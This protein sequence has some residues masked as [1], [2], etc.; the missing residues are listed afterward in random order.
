MTSPFPS[1]YNVPV[2]LVFS[3]LVNILTAKGHAHL[4]CLLPYPDVE[5]FPRDSNDS[6]AHRRS[7]DNSTKS[8]V[9]STVHFRKCVTLRRFPLAVPRHVRQPLYAHWFVCFSVPLRPRGPGARV[10][11]YSVL[12]FLTFC[13]SIFPYAEANTTATESPEPVSPLGRRRYVMQLCDTADNQVGLAANS[14]SSGI[15]GPSP[16]TLRRDKPRT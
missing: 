2:F 14:S 12:L 8:L 4:I 9:V 16:Q 10:K 11:L 3:L 5:L 6:S 13:S 7:S 15:E 1:P